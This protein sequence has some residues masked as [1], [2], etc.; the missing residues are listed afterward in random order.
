MGGGA[1]GGGIIVLIQSSYANTYLPTLE[2]IGGTAEYGG[3][4]GAGQ[5][6]KYGINS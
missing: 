4:G 5:T 2:A 1:S 6:K 3:Y